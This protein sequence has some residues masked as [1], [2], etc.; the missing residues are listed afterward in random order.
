[1]Q[2]LDN[3]RRGAGLPGLGLA[4]EQMPAS[5]PSRVAALLAHCPAAAQ[6]PLRAAPRIAAQAGLAALHLKD[7]RDR[8]GLGSFKA[9]GAAHAI[10]RDAA[11]AVRGSVPDRASL[12]GRTYV[13]ASA[14]NHGLSLAA[15]ARIFGAQ[16]VIYLAE[17]VPEAFAA[18]LRAKGAEVVRAGAVYEES[19]AAAAEAAARHGWRLLS[20]SSWPGYLDAPHAVMEGYL[21]LVDEA[22]AQVPG[23]PDLVLV[24]AGVGGLAASVAAFARARWGAAPRIVVVE[25]EAAP[26]LIES[27]RAGR[28][29]E[30]AGPVSAMGRLDCK[31]PSLIALA[32]LAR[33]ADAFVTVSEAEAAAAVEALAA[34]GIATTPSGAAA[35]APLLGAE[36][37]RL[38]AAG[39]ALAFV[40]EE[41]ESG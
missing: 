38:G 36:A 22:A 33:D 7:E 2:I 18:R 8:M 28:V 10:A 12:A 30:T 39:H 32:G 3:P 21:Q 16:A 20:D 17:T 26:A 14:G 37:A 15:G 29:V 25:P 24:Q 4:P 9:L 11:D 6:T 1:M 13:T 31:T 41:A 27:V 34:E 23:P 5:D 35:I 40:T 19:M